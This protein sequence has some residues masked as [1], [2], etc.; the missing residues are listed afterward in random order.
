M[1]TG[2]FPAA[3]LLL[4]CLLWLGGAAHAFTLA[5]LQ[6]RLQSQAVVR[7]AFVQEKHLR[8][9]DQPLRSTGVFTLASGTGLLWSLTTPIAQ[10]LRI[11]PQGV[12]RR[13]QVNGQTQWIAAPQ[14]SGRENRL[15]LAVLAGD[16]QELQTQFD[17]ALTGS[18][19]HWQLTLTPSSA[20]LRQI[21]SQ[22]QIAGDDQV[23]R[24]ELV[25]TQ[26]DRTVLQ[27]QNVTTDH[28][29]SAEEAHAFLE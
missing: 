27:L 29:L 4:A 14:Q 26:G 3:R 19:T 7:G 2:R 24:I 20:L 21:F 8:G 16:T 1:K 22:I 25:E 13:A 23:K 17:L 10:Q 6:Q 12:A 28:A 11:T 18:Q 5:D 15:F 9:L